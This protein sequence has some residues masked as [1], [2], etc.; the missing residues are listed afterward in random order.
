MSRCCM[1]GTISCLSTGRGSAHPWVFL[2]ALLMGRGGVGTGWGTSSASDRSATPRAMHF[3][4]EHAHVENS[5]V[6]GVCGSAISQGHCPPECLPRPGADS[7]GTNTALSPTGTSGAGGAP[8]SAAQACW[9]A[10]VCSGAKGGRGTGQASAAA[11]CTAWDSTGGV[12]FKRPVLVVWPLP[13]RLRP[14]GK[15]DCSVPPHLASLPAAALRP[16]TGVGRCSPQMPLALATC[17][18]SHTSELGCHLISS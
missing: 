12:Q 16:S 10:A 7:A 6:C 5:R 9:L 15:G 18:H 4:N 8:Y 2:S 1:G 13:G 14:A 17:C 11:Q 3:I